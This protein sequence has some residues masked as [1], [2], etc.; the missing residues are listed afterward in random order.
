MGAVVEYGPCCH[1]QW[2]FLWQ[3][4]G[5]TEKLLDLMPAVYYASFQRQSNWREGGKRKKLLSKATTCSVSLP[6]LL[7]TS[8]ITLQCPV[9]PGAQYHGDPQT[10]L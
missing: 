7:H 4:D 5:G 6:P 3:K 8:H 1:F 10:I 2:R 9:P